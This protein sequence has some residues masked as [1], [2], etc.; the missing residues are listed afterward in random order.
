MFSVFKNDCSPGPGYKVDPRTTRAGVDGT[1][2]Y[3]IL[4]REKDRSK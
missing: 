4:G 1:P 3:S 2:S